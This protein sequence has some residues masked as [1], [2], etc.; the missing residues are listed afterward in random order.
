MTTNNLTYRQIVNEF[1][2]AC[3]AHLEIAKF[4]SGTLDYLDANAVNK[5]YPYIYLRPTGATLTDRLRT[6]N[7]ELYSLDI[8]RVSDGSNVE[9]ISNTEIYIYDLLAWFNFGQTNIQQTYDI[10][11]QNILPVNEAFQDRVFGWVATIN[12]TTPFKLDYCSYPT[13]SL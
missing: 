5:L 4:D 7:F 10:T 13:G 6:L 8:P 2:A 1:T 9:V 12:V 3:N 11:L